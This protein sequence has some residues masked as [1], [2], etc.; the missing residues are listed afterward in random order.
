MLKAPST[1][2]SSDISSPSTSCHSASRSSDGSHGNNQHIELGQVRLSLLYLPKQQQLKVGLIQAENLTSSDTRQAEQLNPYIKLCLMPRKIQRYVST[3]IRH[4]RNPVFDQDFVFTDLHEHEMAEMSLRL[5]V[6][7][8]TAKLG[9]D[10]LLGELQVSM[11]ELIPSQEM[12]LLREL[13]PVTSRNVSILY[14]LFA[15]LCE[16]V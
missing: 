10:E 6:Y 12:R 7:H 14:I 2:S 15:F 4:T 8:K 1:V 13:E 16:H 11:A 5:K 9:R 3:V